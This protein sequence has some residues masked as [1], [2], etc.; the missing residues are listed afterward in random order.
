MQAD[1]NDALEFIA[2]NPSDAMLD[3]A[4]IRAT[5]QITLHATADTRTLT[6]LK[7]ERTRREELPM[8]PDASALWQLEHGTPGHP[9]TDSARAYLEGRLDDYTQAELNAMEGNRDP[10]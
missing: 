5:L 8:W 3:N 4:I 2:L 6:A 7:A 1:L 10:S 9:R